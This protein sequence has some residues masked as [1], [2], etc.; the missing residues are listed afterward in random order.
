MHKGS[1]RNLPPRSSP[2]LTG[3]PQPKVA[4]CVPVPVL[5]DAGNRFR[6]L[7]ATIVYFEQHRFTT[8]SNKKLYGYKIIHQLFSAASFSPKLRYRGCI[9][10][11]GT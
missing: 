5:Y 4:E 7:V 8:C 9:R 6:L 11:L 3:N 1:R 2:W 10:Y